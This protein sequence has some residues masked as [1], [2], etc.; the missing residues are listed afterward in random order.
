M[1]VL[2][3]RSLVEVGRSDRNVVVCC[4]WIDRRGTS[5]VARHEWKRKRFLGVEMD[6]CTRSFGFSS[7]ASDSQPPSPS[8]SLSLSLGSISKAQT[9][10]WCSRGARKRQRKKKNSTK[11]RRRREGRAW[12]GHK[13]SSSNRVDQRTNEGR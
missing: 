1:N 3:Y 6:F 4:E 12:L 13:K 7:T 5:S 10:E 8:L 11:T 2:G 9:I